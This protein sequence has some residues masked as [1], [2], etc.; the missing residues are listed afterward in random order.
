MQLYKSHPLSVGRME[1]Q[2]K[3]ISSVVTSQI[4]GKPYIKHGRSQNGQ[5][6]PS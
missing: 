3:S 6:G 1:N 5:L 2:G 4:E